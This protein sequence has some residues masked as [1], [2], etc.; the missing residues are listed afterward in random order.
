M[1]VTTIQTVITNNPENDYYDVKE[2]VFSE[3]IR[4][5]KEKFYRFLPEALTR[6][7]YKIIFLGKNRKEQIIMRAEKKE[8]IKTTKMTYIVV[9]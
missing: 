8:G 4:F 5:S 3:G 2:E 1:R 6:E 9:A 7:G